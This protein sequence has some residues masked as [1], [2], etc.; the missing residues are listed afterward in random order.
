MIT[1]ES[2]LLPAYWE[3]DGD[4]SL[5]AAEDFRARSLRQRPTPPRSWSLQ[6]ALRLG[7]FH[8]YVDAFA[9]KFVET[10][11]TKTPSNQPQYPVTNQEICRIQRALYRFQ[12]FCNLERTAVNI[13]CNDDFFTK[14]F[15]IFEHEQLFCIYYFLV[16]A[17][18]PAFDDVAEHDVAWGAWNIRSI[19]GPN[20]SSYLTSKYTQ[21]LLSLGLKKVYEIASAETYEQRYRVLDAERRPRPSDF[22][23]RKLDFLRLMRGRPS[24]WTAPE[25]FFD[26]PNSGSRDAIEW[27]EAGCDTGLGEYYHEKLSEWGYVMWDRVRL[28]TVGIFEEPWGNEAQMRRDRRF[29]IDEIYSRY[30]IMEK[31]WLRR[32]SI[33]KAGGSG[34]WSWDDE[35]QVRWEKEGTSGLLGFL[36]EVLAEITPDAEQ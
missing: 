17:V 10:T 28:E 22:L 32:E 3:D 27:R 6:K 1:A 36:T 14:C 18:L 26:D 21:S 19:S 16:R 31:S 24:R 34:W 15:D 25:P 23:Y 2:A 5:E 8:F 30:K 35:S 12:L 4:E 11:L 7:R 33:S 9:K 29:R 20:G 13:N